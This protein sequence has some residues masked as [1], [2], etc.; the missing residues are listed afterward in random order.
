M[1]LTIDELES[2][3]AFIKTHERSDI[4]DSVWDLCIKIQQEMNIY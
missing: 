3:V 4:P 1:E 2:L